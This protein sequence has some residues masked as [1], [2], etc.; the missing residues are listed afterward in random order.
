MSS[1]GTR[2]SFYLVKLSQSSF[3]SKIFFEKSTN[4]FVF[5]KVGAQCSLFSNR[6]PRRKMCQSRWARRERKKL[7]ACLHS[8]NLAVENIR[9]ISFTFKGKR[10]SCNSKSIISHSCL[11]M[12]I[13]LVKAHDN[14]RS[15]D[16]SNFGL[17]KETELQLRAMSNSPK[18]VSKGSSK[19]CFP[20]CCNWL[21]EDWK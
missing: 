17:R 21:K 10:A 12:W 6:V 1:Q 15:N 18:Q 16:V 4:L 9:V 8:T 13:Q 7:M 2:N 11:G 20:C 5:F 14:M 3:E 19:A